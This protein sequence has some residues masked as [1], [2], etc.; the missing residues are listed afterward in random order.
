MALKFKGKVWVL[1]D[2]L[3]VDNELFPFR[4]GDSG[5]IKPS[6]FGQWVM[7]NVDPDFPRKAKKGDIVMTGTNMGCGHDHAEAIKGFLQLGISMVISESFNRNWLRNA[8]YL[9]LPIVEYPGIKKMVK[10][11]DVLEVDLHTGEIKNITSKQTIKFTPLPEFLLDILEAK[12]IDRYTD[13]QVKAG[14]I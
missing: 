8:I 2:N 1:G 5:E 10:E 14:K 7:T 11:G 3:D 13:N 6:E 12:G 4:K 9:G